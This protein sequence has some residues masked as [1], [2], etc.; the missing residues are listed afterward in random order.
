AGVALQMEDEI[1]VAGSGA[2]LVRLEEQLI[3]RLEGADL[4][5]ALDQRTDRKGPVARGLDV[6]RAVTPVL[7]RLQK[8]GRRRVP[9][10]IEDLP[11]NEEPARQAN[12]DLLLAGTARELDEPAVRGHALLLG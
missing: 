2:H 6:H 5:L 8:S 7:A 3:R 12:N 9:L 11:A 4:V 10:R 1:L